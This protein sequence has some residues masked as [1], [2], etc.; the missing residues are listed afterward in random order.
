[1]GPRGVI[2]KIQANGNTPALLSN[3]I[4]V[5]RTVIRNAF[6]QTWVPSARGE[7]DPPKPEPQNTNLLM[8]VVSAQ[9]RTNRQ[10]SSMTK[11]KQIQNT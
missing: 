5:A 2:S 9:A 7:H 10:I 3:L 8:I 11:R 1:M 6:N 4:L